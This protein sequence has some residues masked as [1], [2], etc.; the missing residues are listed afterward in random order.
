[1]TDAEEMEKIEN[2]IADL[3]RQIVARRNRA[4][5]IL[6]GRIRF[7]RGHRFRI[8]RATPVMGGMG[9][10]K[11]FYSGP[12]LKQDGTPSTRTTESAPMLLIDKIE[13]AP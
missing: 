4:V 8:E 10:C 2:E 5:E 12:R 9:D 3:G 11:L 6:R 13:R 7:I 1:M